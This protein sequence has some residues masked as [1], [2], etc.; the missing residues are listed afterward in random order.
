MF[1]KV[2]SRR[3]VAGPITSLVKI[4]I[5]YGRVLHDGLIEHVFN[6]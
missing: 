5:L 6:V 3:K 1:I 4:R 2:V